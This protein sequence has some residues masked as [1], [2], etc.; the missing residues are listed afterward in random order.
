MLE[1]K[2]NSFSI[3]NSSKKNIV[4]LKGRYLGDSE[5]KLVNNLEKNLKE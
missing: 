3:Q 2:T 4:V 1:H 5:K